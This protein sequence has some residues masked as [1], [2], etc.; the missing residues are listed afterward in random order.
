MAVTPSAPDKMVL[1]GDHAAVYGE[2][3]LVTTVDLRFS[4][5]IDVHDEAVVEISTPDLRARNETHRVSLT[6]LRKDN[7]RDTAFVE[8]ALQQVFQHCSPTPGMKIT[9]DGP[10]ITY[11]LGS[12]SAITAATI[13]AAAHTLGLRLSQRDI[14]DLAYAAVIEVQGTG[15]GVDLAAAI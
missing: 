2:P 9:T 3:C 11:G 4:V 10:R 6:E 5:T 15:S 7:R 8:A 12:S 13:A 1:F 14:F